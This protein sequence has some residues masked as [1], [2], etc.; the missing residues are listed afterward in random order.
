MQIVIYK[1][2]RNFDNLSIFNL[3]IFFMIFL[4]NRFFCMKNDKSSTIF[5]HVEHE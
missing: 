4:T 2:Q 1:M 3:T 5:C